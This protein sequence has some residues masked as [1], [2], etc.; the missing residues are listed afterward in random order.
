MQQADDWLGV[1]QVRRVVREE[2]LF[3]SVGRLFFSG[4]AGLISESSMS[5]HL[6][7]STYLK[8]KQASTHVHTPVRQS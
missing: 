6:K 1:P 2:Q 4:P 5:C 3:F 7:V 8:C